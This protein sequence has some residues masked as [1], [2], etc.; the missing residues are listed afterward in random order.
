MKMSKV[1][2]LLLFLFFALLVTTLGFCIVEPTA[3]VS[4]A[5]VSEPISHVSEPVTEV[6]TG[7]HYSQEPMPVSYETSEIPIYHPVEAVNESRIYVNNNTAMYYYLILN[8]HTHKYDTISASTKEQLKAKVLEQTKPKQDNTEKLI[9]VL[10]GGILLVLCVSLYHSP[11]KK[12]NE[13]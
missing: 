13:D 7:S 1:A 5:H 10:L 11:D 6:N 3:H 2:C 9:L 4:T 8:N 12:R